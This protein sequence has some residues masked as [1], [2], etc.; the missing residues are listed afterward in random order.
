MFEIKHKSLALQVNQ[1]LSP[2]SIL[3]EFRSELVLRASS[4]HHN[5]K[6]HMF[7]H[8]LADRKYGGLEENFPRAPKRK[9]LNNIQFPHVA[10]TVRFSIF[11]LLRQEPDFCQLVRSQLLSCATSLWIRFGAE[12]CPINKSSAEDGRRKVSRQCSIPNRAEWILW[13][14]LMN[15][16]LTF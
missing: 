8:L 2:T 6:R 4:S 10:F 13:I 14:P 1:L 11:Q 7:T 15:H 12:C 9:S 16:M 3:L 5:D